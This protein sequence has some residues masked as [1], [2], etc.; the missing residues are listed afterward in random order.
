MIGLHVCCSWSIEFE[1]Q[2]LICFN[3]YL[4]WYH[5]ISLV[6]LFTCYH[7]LLSLF[8]IIQWSNPHEPKQNWVSMKENIFVGSKEWVGLQEH[9]KTLNGEDVP[10]AM[11]HEEKKEMV[12]W[13]SSFLIWAIGNLNIF[14]YMVVKHMYIRAHL[15]HLTW[16]FIFLLI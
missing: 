7:S 10:H 8:I 9:L 4:I 1:I 11:W 15:F 5:V 12:G 14:I 16:N 2:L 6:Y 3:C 13:D